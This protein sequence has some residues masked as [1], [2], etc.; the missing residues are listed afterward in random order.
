MQ[1]YEFLK[2]AEEYN[3]ALSFALDLASFLL[4]IEYD[5]VKSLYNANIDDKAVEDVL[6]KVKNHIPVAYITG[7]KEFY[8][9]EFIVNENVLIPRVET[10]ILVE[11]VLKRYKCSSNLDII[12]IC[13]G[14]GAIGLTVIQEIRNCH[15]TLLDISKD[16]VKVSRQ[17]ARKFNIENHI[18]FIC[19]DILLYTSEKKYDIVLCNPPYITMEE[20]TAVEEEVKKEPIIAL[21]AEDNGLKFYKNILSKFSLLCKDNGVMFFEIGAMQAEQ[22]ISIAKEHNLYAECVKDYALNDRVI[23]VYSK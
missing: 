19:D 4:N 17:N 12:D 11:E 6:N 23:I 15:V 9:R 5:K 1:V 20:Y 22:V 21:V 3:I 13:S 2:K 8:G 10:E 14:S 7:R 18:D 16:A